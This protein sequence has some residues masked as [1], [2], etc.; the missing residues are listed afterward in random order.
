[1]QFEINTN[2]FT[3]IKY[4]K[5]M[6]VIHN[7]PQLGIKFECVSLDLEQFKSNYSQPHT[8]NATVFFNARLQDGY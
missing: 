5:L 7:H 4:N 6:M 1:M 8:L 3:N 2:M